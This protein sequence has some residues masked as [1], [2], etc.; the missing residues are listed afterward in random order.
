MV[1]IQSKC[2]KVRSRKTPNT[3]Y[4]HAVVIGNI[5]KDA[6]RNIPKAL[7]IIYD[8]TFCE[9]DLW[10]NARK[11]KTGKVRIREKQGFL[12]KALT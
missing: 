8:G 1:R 9:N 10:L 6:C 4:F 11:K 12:S 5:P 7:S 2:G 3:D